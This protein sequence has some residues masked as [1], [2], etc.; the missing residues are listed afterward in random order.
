VSSR[1]ARA[2]EKPCLEKQ[3]QK[4][5]ILEKEFGSI[6]GNERYSL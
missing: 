6:E 1:T 5:K 2:A 4:K 3:K